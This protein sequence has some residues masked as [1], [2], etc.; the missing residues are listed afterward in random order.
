[1]QI[2][3]DG[4]AAATENPTDDSDADNEERS[5]NQIS[6]NSNEHETDTNHD[7]NHNHSSIEIDSSGSESDGVEI[8]EVLKPYRGNPNFVQTEIVAKNEVFD[9]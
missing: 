5:C 8:V 1:M 7:E 4:L 3:L 6:N 2:A 9:F